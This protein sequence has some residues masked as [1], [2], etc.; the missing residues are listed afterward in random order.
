MRRKGVVDYETCN[1]FS[2]EDMEDLINEYN[3]KDYAGMLELKKVESEGYKNYIEWFVDRW[4]EPSRW[5]ASKRRDL[6]M[7]LVKTGF[8][9]PKYNGIKPQ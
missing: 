7:S 1:D 2:E 9:D 8:L 6:L 3:S 5:P 4:I